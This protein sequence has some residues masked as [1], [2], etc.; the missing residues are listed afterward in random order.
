M[1]IQEAAWGNAELLEQNRLRLLEDSERKMREFE[2]RYE[3]RS[4]RVE[5]EMDAGRLR[6]TAEICDWVIAYHRY[7]S[8]KNAR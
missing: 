3:L 2:A 4:D 5:A 7:C 1:A 8:L 6:E